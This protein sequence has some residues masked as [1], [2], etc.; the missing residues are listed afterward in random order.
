MNKANKNNDFFFQNI[1]VKLTVTNN[2][3][4]AITKISHK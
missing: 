4:V 2:V 3:E 1:L